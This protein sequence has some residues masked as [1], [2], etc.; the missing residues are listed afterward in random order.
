MPFTNDCHVASEK[1]HLEE[2]SFTDDYHISRKKFQLSLEEKILSIGNLNRWQL[3]HRQGKIPSRGKFV[4][5]YLRQKK[6][7]IFSSNFI[8]WHL[9]Q[10]FIQANKSFLFIWLIDCQ[11]NFIYLFLANA[12]DPTMLQISY[13]IKFC[14]VL[15]RVCTL[16]PNNVISVIRIIRNLL[17][18]VYLV[19]MVS[20]NW[21]SWQSKC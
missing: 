1:F 16:F 11:A 9:E 19:I 14:K 3:S 21:I 18:R 10:N 7:R 20:E 4:Q 6:N 8:H 15:Y 17:V 2:I 13:C 5:W 12:A